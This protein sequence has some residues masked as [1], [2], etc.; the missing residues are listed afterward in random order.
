MELLGPTRLA[1]VA[2]ESA[3]GPP[4][5]VGN[6]WASGEGQQM[7][8]AV[9]VPAGQRVHAGQAVV[10]GLDANQANLFDGRTGENLKAKRPREAIPQMGAD[11]VAN[12]KKEN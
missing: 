8:L 2:V 5:P 1:W 3:A 4:E 11:S 10:V 6:S 9:L 12:P 7:E